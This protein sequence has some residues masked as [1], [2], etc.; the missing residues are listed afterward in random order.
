MTSQPGPP[1]RRR[2]NRSTDLGAL[3]ERRLQ[4]ARWFAQGKSQAE[5]ARLLGVSRQS[6]SRWYQAWQRGG[7][8]GLKSAGRIGRRPRLTLERLQQVEQALLQ[9]ARAHGYA[10]DLWTLP[11]IARLIWQL[12]GVRYHPGHVWKILRGMGWSAQR[13]QR[14]AKE[15]DEQAISRWKRRR[16]PQRKRGR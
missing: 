15:R 6:A 2:A 10:S 12:T 4:A 8:A 14:Q 5:V 13:P 11:R 16:W 1:K 3:E 7:A 9:G